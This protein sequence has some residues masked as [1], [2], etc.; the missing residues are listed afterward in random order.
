MKIYLI[1]N[2][3]NNNLY[4]MSSFK[5][6]ALY[7]NRK[8]E[9]K[10]TN[11][12]SRY[13]AG[14]KPDW[15]KEES[16]SEEEDIFPDVVEEKQNLDIAVNKIELNRD[17]I[18]KIERNDRRLQRLETNRN[19]S[20]PDNNVFEERLKRRREI[21][22]SEIVSENKSS[23]IG[24]ESRRE[25][26]KRIISE[27]KTLENK[28]ED[29]ENELLEM[30]GNDDDN[31]EF[32]PEE[33]NPDEEENDSYEEEVLMRPVFVSKEDR[34]TIQDEFHKEMEEK[35]LIEQQDKMKELKKKQTKELVNKYIEADSKKD[36]NVLDDSD[37]STMPDDTDNLDD[38]E[39][40]EKWKL[41][42]LKRIKRQIEDDEK[43]LKERLEIERRRNLSNEQRKEEN[44]RLGSDDTLRPFKSK[45]NF[46]QR[47]YHRGAFY[48]SDAQAN[49][50]HVY[51]RDYNLPVAEDKVDLSALPEI[52]QVRRGNLFKKG[53]SKYKHLTAEDTSNFDPN[54]KVPEHLVNKIQSNMAGYKAKDTF[55]LTSKKHKR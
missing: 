3:N 34:K 40:Y 23:A 2:I 37:D 39:E 51:N 36:E 6:S 54:Y 43:K 26:M 45:I 31:A 35:A 38:L 14:F 13:R 49:L 22:K 55:E 24:T 32:N 16:E 10:I 53:R 47:Y 46:L 5:E 9:N 7:K 48:Q 11:Q 4:S 17:M 19:P 44:L 18:E 25:V 30:L 15:V 8:E 42:E 12:A 50:D 29:N 21:Y 33:N 41:R 52:M 28:V 20:Q 27:E 1:F